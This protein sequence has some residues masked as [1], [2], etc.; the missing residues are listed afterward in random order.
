MPAQA[1]SL[2]GPHTHPSNVLATLPFSESCSSCHVGQTSVGLCGSKLFPRFGY[3]EQLHVCEQ[4]ASVPVFVI[5]GILSFSWPVSSE[6]KVSIVSVYPQ[7]WLLLCIM[8]SGQCHWLVPGDSA[9]LSEAP[10]L[11]S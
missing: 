8:P 9:I 6:A 3:M 10:S 7:P 2:R 11:Q 4:T 5:Y 1:A